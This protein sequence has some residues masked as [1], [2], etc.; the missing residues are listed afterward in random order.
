MP[1]HR[2]RCNPNRSTAR[3]TILR[4]EVATARNT[5]FPISG[6]AR[7][8]S[9]FREHFSRRQSQGCNLERSIQRR[10]DCRLNRLLYDSG[11][12]HHGS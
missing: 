5:Y 9:R 10:R 3:G 1:F 11:R 8:L 4:P 12:Y 6:K 7:D 2:M